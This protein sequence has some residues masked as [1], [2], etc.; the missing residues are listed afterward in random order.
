[1]KKNVEIRPAA[2]A[3]AASDEYQGAGN[4]LRP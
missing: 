1:M 2:E 4:N 3:D